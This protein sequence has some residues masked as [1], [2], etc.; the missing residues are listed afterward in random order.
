MKTTLTEEQQELISQKD[1]FI[2]QKAKLLKEYKGYEKDLEFAQDEFEEG[3]ILDR[4][5]KLAK[6]IKALGEKIR[7]A[8]SLE[9]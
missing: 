8:E 9:A 6:Q 2:A 4:R 7:E 1:E 3:L 5:E